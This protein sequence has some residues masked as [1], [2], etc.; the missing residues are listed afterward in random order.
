MSGRKANGRAR[1]AGEGKDPRVDDSGE[2]EFGGPWGVGA[3][4]VFFPMLM[5]ISGSAP[6]TMTVTYQCPKRGKAGG[7]S[8]WSW[9]NLIYGGAS[10]H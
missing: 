1:V 3:M 7:T 2:F 6:H 5:Y 8:S 4:M 10:Q 9:L